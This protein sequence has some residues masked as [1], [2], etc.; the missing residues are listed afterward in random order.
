MARYGKQSSGD[1]TFVTIVILAC[2][3]W[4]HR[5]LV[6]KA[7]Q[8]AVVGVVVASSFIV[9]M[10][11]LKAFKR[12][13]SWRSPRKASLANVDTMTG[14]EFEKLVAKLLKTQ[15]YEKIRFTEKYDYGIDLIASK[16]GV[17]WGIQTKRYNG[18]VKASAVRQV[19]TA[20]RKYNCSRAMVVTNSEFSRVA[21][22]LAQSND[23]VLVGRDQLSKWLTELE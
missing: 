17:T 11:L 21:K 22:E 14:L 23:C 3:W 10:Y 18:L 7:E 12:M 2:I 13:T 6:Q 19:V 5:A 4:S 9:A 1:F 16:D 8:Y 15:G 20:L